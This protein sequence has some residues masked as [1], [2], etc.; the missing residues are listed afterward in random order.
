M[1]NQVRLLLLQLQG[2]LLHCPTSLVDAN[3]RFLWCDIGGAGHMSDA[4]IFNGSELK[5]AM[6]NR[7]IG[8]PQKIHCLY[9]DEDTPY[10]L[11]ADDAFALRTNLM[12]PYSTRGMTRSQAMYNYRISRGRRVVR[13]AFGIM[14]NRFRAFLG[15]MQQSPEVVQLIVKC[16]VILHNMMRRRYPGEQP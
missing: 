6:D 5:E 13:N 2:V 14:A 4:Q 9:D 11:L 16:Y 3:Y 7:T 15:R 8:F 1:P 12:K 10:F